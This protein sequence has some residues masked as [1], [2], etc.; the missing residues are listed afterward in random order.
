MKPRY[1]A[2]PL[3]G[4]RDVIQSSV[5]SVLPNLRPGELQRSLPRPCPER[6]EVLRRAMTPDGDKYPKTA[7]VSSVPEPQILG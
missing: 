5:T 6:I 2:V 3:P 1:L 7:L 4:H